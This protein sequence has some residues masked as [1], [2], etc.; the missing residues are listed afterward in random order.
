MPNFLLK[1]AEVSVKY[2][3]DGAEPR[4]GDDRDGVM[5]RM[6]NAYFGSAS[7][8]AVDIIPPPLRIK[9][10]LLTSQKWMSALGRHRPSAQA[11][12]ETHGV[13][14]RPPCPQPVNTSVPGTW[15]DPAIQRGIVLE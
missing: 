1:A 13:S 15:L 5:W 6:K 2:L 4:W 8:V 11:P 10:H 7:T 3:G 12:L 14:R 9:I